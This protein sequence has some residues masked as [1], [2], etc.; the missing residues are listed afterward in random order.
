MKCDVKNNNNLTMWLINCVLLDSY[1]KH[2]II[3]P[4]NKTHYNFYI[5]PSG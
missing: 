1:S 2:V 3:K 4:T 5:L